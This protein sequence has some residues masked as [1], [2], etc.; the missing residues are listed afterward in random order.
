ME[1]MWGKEQ[2]KS[3]TLVWTYVRAF[4]NVYPVAHWN[5]CSEFFKKQL[6]CARR[7]I[8]HRHNW[9]RSINYQQYI[10]GE[11]LAT[12]SAL[13]SQLLVHAW[14]RGVD[15]PTPGGREIDSHRSLANK[16]VGG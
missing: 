12:V 1:L 3:K 4:A 13:R 10:R 14:A 8:G 2:R 9:V 7:I 11:E 6:L 16:L 5:L 15:K